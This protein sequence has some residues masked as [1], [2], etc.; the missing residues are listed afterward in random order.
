MAYVAHSGRPAGYNEG[1]AGNFL[2]QIAAL[3]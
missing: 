1:P 2:Q 3:P